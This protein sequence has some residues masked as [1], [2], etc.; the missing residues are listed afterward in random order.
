MNEEMIIDELTYRSYAYNRDRFPEI[1]PQRWTT[2]YPHADAME[3]RYQAAANKH[4]QAMIERD[5]AMPK[6]ERDMRQGA[7]EP[8]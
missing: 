3:R 8:Q 5:R 6:W 2:I 1:N 4:A 7:R